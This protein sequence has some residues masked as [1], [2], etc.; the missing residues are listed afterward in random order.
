MRTAGSRSRRS[1]VKV[2]VLASAAL[3]L[4]ACAPPA[5]AQGPAPSGTGALSGS[6]TIFA[7]ASLTASFTE[8]AKEFGSANPGVSVAPISFDGSSTLATQIAEGAPADVFAS[9]DEASMAR[10]VDLI[11]GTPTDFAVNVL[12]I[13]VQPGNPLGI[14]GLADLAKPG[15][16]V[17]LCAPEVPCG[18]AS[19]RILALDRVA[20]TPVSEEQNVKAVLTKVQTK[21]ADAGLVYLTDV[22][23]AA[24]S[25]DGVD[26]AGADRAANSYPIAALKASAHPDVAGAFVDFVLSSRG[27]AVLAK[28]GFTA[29]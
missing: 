1:A 17:V 21:E 7:A 20:V 15:I 29:P 26:I 28:Y 5:P 8:L 6:L 13:A 24:G 2:A 19:R 14:S 12:Q 27:Q 23:A 22:A 3:L 9:A 16:Q 10:V 11:D 4:P 25:V 18:A